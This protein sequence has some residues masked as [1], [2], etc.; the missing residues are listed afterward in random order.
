MPNNHFHILSTRPLPQQLIQ[1]AAEKNS[2]VDCTSFIE[3]KPLHDDFIFIATEKYGKHSTVVFTSMTAVEALTNAVD[4]TGTR[5]RIAC[6]EGTTLNLVQNKF[7]NSTIIATASN[8]KQ[9][10]EKIIALNNDK[11]IAF[12]CGDKRRD[13]LP[14]LLKENNIEVE[15][16]VLYKTKFTPVII[17]KNY[18]AILFFSPSA[19]ESFFSVNKINATTVLY[20]IGKTTA[21]TIKQFSNNKIIES[22]SP[23]K[24]QLLKL[25]VEALNKIT[26]E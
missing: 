14:A 4:T 13:E 2:E 19:V 11:Y 16:V 10:A 7:P 22:A 23:S 3:T 1:E 24:E 12:F 6:M 25:A 21:E 26:N 5:W 20:A 18:D 15:E 17:D 9:L 8:A